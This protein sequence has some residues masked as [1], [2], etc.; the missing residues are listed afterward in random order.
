MLERLD[1][2]RISIHEDARSHREPSVSRCRHRVVQSS[3]LRLRSYQV[4][5]TYVIYRL[6]YDYGVGV[7]TSTG[8]R[9]QLGVVGNIETVGGGGRGGSGGL[10]YVRIERTSDLE[11]ALGISADVSGSVGLF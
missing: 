6:G 3:A 10:Q 11:K 1:V 4:E 7:K 9:M 2:S 8:D 5:N